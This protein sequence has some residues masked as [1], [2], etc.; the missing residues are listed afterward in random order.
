MSAWPGIARRL[1]GRIVAMEPVAPE[2]E[3]GL[4]VAAAHPEIWTWL[5]DYVGETPERFSAWFSELRAA[6]AAGDEQA[7]IT[8]ARATGAPIG[9][10]RFLAMRPVDRVLEIGWTWLTPAAWRTGVNVEAKLLML[11]HAFDNLGCVRVEFKTDARND[12]SRQAIE[13]IPAQFEGIFRKHKATRRVGQRDSAY[14]SV[15]DDEWP[16]VRA[17]LE[18]RLEARVHA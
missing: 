2:H 6:T 14:Y 4:A 10:S 15:I 18:R 9:S 17:N 12:Q 16:G 11:S 3:A 8:V 13:A 7:F 1:E 5:D